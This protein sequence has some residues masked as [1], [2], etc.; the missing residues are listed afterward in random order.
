MSGPD[1]SGG[2]LFI[3]TTRLEARRMKDQGWWWHSTAPRFSCRIHQGALGLERIAVEGEPA[4]QNSALIPVGRVKP[5]Y[6]DLIAQYFP[7]KL[8]F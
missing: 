4:E 1:L 3:Q 8:D 5:Y 2:S 7:A 6:L